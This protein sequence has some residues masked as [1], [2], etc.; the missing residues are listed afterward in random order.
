M[1]R[2]AFSYPTNIYQAQTQ[3]QA[4]FGTLSDTGPVWK[5]FTDQWERQTGQERVPAH[6]HGVRDGE[7]AV[8]REHRSWVPHFKELAL[9]DGRFWEIKGK[10]ATRA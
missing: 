1:A 5:K 2:E 7:N 9:N 6:R 10:G 4:M 3:F 8:L